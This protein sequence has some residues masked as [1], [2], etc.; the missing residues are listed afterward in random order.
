MTELMKDFF[1]NNQ[2]ISPRKGDG[3]LITTSEMIEGDGPYVVCRMDGYTIL[4]TEQYEKILKET[5]NE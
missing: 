4:P 2:I 3:P 5:E 1:N